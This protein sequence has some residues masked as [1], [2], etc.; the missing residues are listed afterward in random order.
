M[1]NPL[2]LPTARDDKS[3][4]SVSLCRF[5]CVFI[6]MAAGVLLSAIGCGGGEEASNTT[7]P[8][9]ALASSTEPGN[10]GEDTEAGSPSQQV[11]D[12]NQEIESIEQLLEN[13]DIASAEQKLKALLVRDPAD[14]EVIFRLATLVAGRGDLAAGVE[15]LE[16]IPVDHP[17][18]GLP[19]LGQS[20]E[21]C[22]ALDRFR[23]AE[24]RYKQILAVVPDAKQVHRALAYLYNRQ[25]RRHEA[26]THLYALCQQAD[27]LQDELHALIQWSDA[28]YTPPGTPVAASERPYYPIGPEAE[29][30][31]LFMEYKYQKAVDVLRESVV[32]GEQPSAVV[33]LFGRAAAEAQDASAI[34]WWLANVDSSMQKHA[35]YWAANGLLLSAENRL[36]ESGRALIE[37][38]ARDPT[39]FRSISRLRSVMES[40]GFKDEAIRLEERFKI[41]ESIARTNNRIVDAS[42]PDVQAMTRMAELLDSVD[43]KLEASL[44]RLLAGFHQQLPQ[45]ELQKINTQWSAASVEWNSEAAISARICRLD[46]DQFPLPKLESLQKSGSAKGILVTPNRKQLVP[47]SFV[48]R[49]DQVQLSHTYQVAGAAQPRGFSVYQSVGG[50]VAVLD[51]DLDGLPDLY[52]AQGGCDPPSFVGESSNQLLRGLVDGTVD[53]TEVAEASEQRYSLGVTAGDWNQDGFVDLVIANI[54]TNTLLIN[55]G[56]GTFRREAIDNRDDKNVMTTSLAMGDLTGDHLPDLFEVNYVDDPQISKRPKRN[57]AGDVTETLMPKFFQPGLDRLIIGNAEGSPTFMDMG[58]IETDAKAGLG[59]V[60]SDFDHQPGN[61]VFVGNDVYANQWWRREVDHWVDAAK[62]TGCAY[63]FSGAKTASMGIASGDFDRNG[64]LDFHITNFQGESVSHYLNQQGMYQDRNVQFGFSDVSQSVLGFGAQ[65]ID[66][67]NDGDLDLM[68]T[69]GH[70]E[71]SIASSAPFQQPAQF[72]VNRGDRFELAKVD[73]PSG[74]W[75]ANHLGRG[76]ARVDWNRDGL[77]D[78]VVTH[79]GEPTALLI[80]QTETENHWL[81][82]K[83]RGVKSER[84]AIGARVELQIADQTITEWV[85]AGDG[86]FCR[87]EPVLNFGLGIERTVE[88]ITIYWP[89]GMSQVI[90]GLSADHRFLIV[91]E[92]DEPFALDFTH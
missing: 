66:Y 47:A 42:S 45:E 29:A 43:R 64:W 87:N 86:F 80:N 8:N 28:M 61:E 33:A 92:N 74:Y 39:D 13:G 11:F 68:V 12:R 54:G 36:E 89:S 65:A 27:V 14:A 17:D 32:A 16:S 85:M 78:V 50:A 41:L 23:D 51:F 52:L 88:Q 5:R 82:L 70:I 19:A 57:S 18:A 91:E 67:D 53:V 75:S 3:H 34:E 37:A 2:H 4:F 49:A 35:D 24:D 62:I 56:D 55:N 15:L 84:D 90:R 26:A 77:S 6:L 79:L 83:L 38:L 30:R 76:L 46:R 1:L 72:F 22:F 25:G 40:L 20:A 31:R 58:K 44:W 59:V 48:N 60:V 69:N 21:W 73:D 9:Q 10:D 71:D 63:G 7:S 81:Q